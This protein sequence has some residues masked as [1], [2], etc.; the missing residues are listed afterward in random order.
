MKIWDSLSDETKEII[1]KEIEDTFEA[2]FRE[3]YK[4][5]KQKEA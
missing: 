1:A 5:N 3:F 2:V 4:N